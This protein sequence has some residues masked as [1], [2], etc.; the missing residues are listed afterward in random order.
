[1]KFVVVEESTALSVLEAVKELDSVKEV[2][3]IGKHPGCTPVEQLMLEG[4]T[5]IQLIL[6][7][8]KFNFDNLL[9]LSK[10]RVFV[11]LSNVKCKLLCRWR[12]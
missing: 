4:P 1:M 2:F 11:N 3:V 8:E 12:N 7:L 10:F 9:K 5:N 6:F